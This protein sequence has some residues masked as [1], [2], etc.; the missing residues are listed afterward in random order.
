[1]HS[2][3]NILFLLF[4]RKSMKKIFAALFILLNLSCNDGNFEIPSFEFEETVN[5]CDEYLLYKLSTNEQLETLM[6]TLTTQQI[7]NSEEIVAPVQVAPTGL[8]QV[9]YRIFD[10]KVTSSYFCSLVPPTEPKTVKNWVG[11]DGIIFV[12]N[13]AVFNDD[14]TEIIAYNHI[15]SIEN[16]V[17]ENGENK[18]KFD[19]IYEYGEFQT[20]VE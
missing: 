5:Y 11:I 20:P 19:A 2:E 18:M 14:E 13:E 17:L 6:V 8:F 7:K 12:R 1:M 10:D 4:I 3:V 16:L 15:I 9:T